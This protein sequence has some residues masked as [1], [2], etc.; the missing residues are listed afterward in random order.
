[1]PS[2]GFWLPV[3]SKWKQVKANPTEKNNVLSKKKKGYTHT[4]N[5]NNNRPSQKEKCHKKRK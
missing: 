4:L 5:N 2:K 3:Y 1:M